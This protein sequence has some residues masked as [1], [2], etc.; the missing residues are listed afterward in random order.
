MKSAIPV[1]YEDEDILVVS[2]PSGI[3]SIPDRFDPGKENLL[4]ILSEQHG[5]TWVVHRLDRETSGLL[6]FARNEEAHRQLSMQFENREVQ[7]IYSALVE[8]RIPDEEG[9]ID[10]P[11]AESRTQAG[12]MMV[13]NHGKPSYTLYRVVERFRFHTLVDANIMTG[14][15]HQIRVHFSAIGFPLAVDSLY[16]NHSA[17][18]LSD[19]K[20]S[21][22]H[23]GKYQEERPMMERTSL[24]ARKLVIRHPVS[25]EWVHFES[26]WPRDFAA[27]INQ[28]R[29]WA[30]DKTFTRS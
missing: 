25:G 9:E 7:K 3:L 1:I 17:F 5:R 2:K 30:P 18:Y 16:G 21:K 28:L 29:K 12:K 20:G 23:L 10:L 13:A 4:D 11:I 14:R 15:T 24:H 22:Y 27:V 19:I 6:L 8:G 26:E